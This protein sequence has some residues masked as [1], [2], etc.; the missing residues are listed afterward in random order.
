MTNHWLKEIAQKQKNPV[1]RKKKLKSK[2]FHFK[3]N[4]DEIYLTQRQMEVSLLLLKNLT[5]K[6]IGQNLKISA[7]TVECHVNILRIKL[8]CKNKKKLIQELKKIPFDPAYLQLLNH[9]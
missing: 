5:Y 8:N 1:A 2:R 6:K 9:T 4:S 3:V 7:R